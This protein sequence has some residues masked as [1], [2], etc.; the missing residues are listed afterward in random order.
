[1]PMRTTL[2]HAARLLVLA[3]ACA[4][5]SACADRPKV[6]RLP[7]DAVVLAFGDSLTFGT[8]ASEAASYPSQ[9]ERLIGRKVVR[10][11][12]PGEVSATGLARLPQVLEEHHPELLI[13]VHGGNDLLRKLDKAQAAGN[14]RS[15]V[16][17]ARDKGIAVVVVGVPEPGLLVSTAGFYADIAEEFNLPY[18]GG[19]LSKVLRDNALKSD[20]IHPNAEGYKKIAEALAQLLKETGAI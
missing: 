9:L 13:L 7:P 3:V 16:K 19:I 15:M 18:E 2:R 14:L 8:G 11:G 12:V 4:L 5:V 20:L 10:A 6:A 17:L 1:M